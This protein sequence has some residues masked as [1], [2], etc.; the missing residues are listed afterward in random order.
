[1]CKTQL[2]AQSRRFNATELPQQIFKTDKCQRPKR[3]IK[4]CA[5]TIDKNKEM[6]CIKLHQI[7]YKQALFTSTE[8]LKMNSHKSKRHTFRTSVIAGLLAMI[9]T[10]A[11]A[12]LTFEFNFQGDFIGS[13]PSQIIARNAVITSGQLFSNMFATHFT[14]TATISF[15]VISTTSGLAAAGSAG[16]TAT[17]FGNGEVIRNKIISGG[18]N[19]LNGAASDGYMFFNLATNFEYDPAATV[20][21]A[22]GQIDFYSVVDHELTHAFGFG[23]N[24]GAAGDT[25]AAYTK[26][27]Q[28]LA[29]KGGT[30]IVNTDGTVNLDAYIDAQTN[31]GIFTGANARAAYGS[32]VPLVQNEDI[33]H[34][35]THEFSS[36]QVDQNA[37]LLCCGG[38]NVNFEPR[39]YN[40][41]EIGILTDLGYTRRVSEVPLPASLPLM[42]SGLGALG[43]MRKCRPVQ[44]S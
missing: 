42:V 22:N 43:F 7:F 2:F 29:T 30:S 31:G 39:D 20:D 34:L 19:D 25:P 44:V 12:A 13:T 21:F 8:G 15:D 4:T 11:Q 1:M 17:G 3:A 14:D 35:A 40:L 27:D 24:I 16:I 33:S 37:L 28:F 10:S 36:P 26:W 5:F 41:A 9:G 23:S 32:Y 6:V 18:A 38:E